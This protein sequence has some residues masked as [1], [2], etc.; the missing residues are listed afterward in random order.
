MHLDFAPTR[1]IVVS[2]ELPEQFSLLLQAKVED[3]T[4]L[5]PQQN[6]DAI[7]NELT[8]TTPK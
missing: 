7:K 5:I 3:G 6:Y 4:V 2:V 8:P 1:I